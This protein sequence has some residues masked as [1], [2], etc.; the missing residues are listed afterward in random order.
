MSES[1]LSLS[2]EGRW[3]VCL[4]FQHAGEPEILVD[5]D[6]MKNLQEKLKNMENAIQHL[7]HLDEMRARDLENARR[8]TKSV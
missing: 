2:K 8:R 5:Y 4:K 7:L 1:G 3:K 6:Y